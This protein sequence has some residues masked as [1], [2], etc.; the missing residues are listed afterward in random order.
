MGFESGPKIYKKGTWES[1][2]VEKKADNPQDDDQRVRGFKIEGGKPKE[3]PLAE[4]LKPREY[5]EQT[6]DQKVRRF[7]K[8]PEGLKEAPWGQ[9][10]T[11]KEKE[12]KEELGVWESALENAEKEKAA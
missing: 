10:M 1:P 12:Q 7:I 6:E 5:P 4:A 11:A 8:T 3:I 9:P 2:P